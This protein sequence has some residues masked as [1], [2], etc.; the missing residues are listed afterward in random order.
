MAAVFGNFYDALR[1]AGVPDEKALRASEEL[2]EQTSDVGSLRTGLKHLEESIAKLQ[3]DISALH[4]DVSEL[5]AGAA[6]V[7]WMIGFNIAMSVAIV[8][9]LF[10]SH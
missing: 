1:S 4:E 10:L 9:K 2:F 7:R 6:V 8:G 3:A 5:R